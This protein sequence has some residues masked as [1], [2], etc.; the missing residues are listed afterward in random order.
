MK[1]MLFAAALSLAAPIM[2][3]AAASAGT[4]LTAGA[5]GEI[6]TP[7]TQA[8]VF[9]AASAIGTIDFNLIGY[10]TLDG[11]DCCTDTLTVDLNGVT[12]LQVAFNLGGG[13]TSTVF[14]GSP[15]ITNY[16]SGSPDVY[17]GTA[18]GGSVDVGLS[19]VTFLAGS[20]TLTFTYSG[21]DQ[22][23]ADEA[24][25]LGSVSAGA[26]PEPASWT[27]LITGFGLVGFAARRRRSVIAA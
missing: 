27:M 9:N 4:Y 22:G 1:K 13:G 10:R 7:G 15:T 2:L 3:P 14:T 18:L 25:G 8:Y 11:V 23:I 17:N 26:V 20:N 12:L 24:W 16:T 21:A 19:G 5:T 6:G